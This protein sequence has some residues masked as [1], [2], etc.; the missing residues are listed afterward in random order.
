MPAGHEAEAVAEVDA[1]RSAGVG[2]IVARGVSRILPGA[3]PVT[4]VR[5]IDLAIG[6]GEFVAIT[7]PSGSGKSSLLYLLGLLDR[8]SSGR[9][10]HSTAEYPGSIGYLA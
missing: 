8:P 10:F 6:K 3:V 5:D 7:G 2:G 1:G 9:R 4:L